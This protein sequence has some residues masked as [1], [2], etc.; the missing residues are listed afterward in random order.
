MV[1]AVLFAIQIVGILTSTTGVEAYLLDAYPEGSGEVG[2]WINLSRAFGGCMAIYIQLEWVDQAGPKA[3][4]G[5]QAGITAG[6]MLIILFLQVFGQKL[7]A[8][9]GPMELSRP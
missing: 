8:F 1:L 4:F 2:A 5:I 6:S 3:V 9:Q 7:R